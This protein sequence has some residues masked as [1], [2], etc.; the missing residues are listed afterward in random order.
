MKA[1]GWWA[2]GGVLGGAIVIAAVLRLGDQSSEL[3]GKPI[4]AELQSLELSH[5]AVK[6]SAPLLVRGDSSAEYALG[7]PTDD[8]QFPNAW[9]SA[10]RARGDGLVYA[11]M[12]GSAHLQVTCRQVDDV[13]RG[14]AS[15]RNVLPT[16]AKFLRKVCE[17]G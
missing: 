10:S 5:R 17:A 12:P 13:L 7:I 3:A 9:I 1:S 16:V 4:Y 8:A 11:V 15:S 6:L 14:A 2:A